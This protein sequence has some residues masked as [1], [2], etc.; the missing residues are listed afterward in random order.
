M[1][2]NK[3]R[4]DRWRTEIDNSIAAIA[5]RRVVRDIRIVHEDLRR[6]L[7]ENDLQRTRIAWIAALTL[8]RSVGHVLAKVDTRR[9]GWLKDAINTKHQAVKQDMFHNLIFH[10]FIE[11]ERNVVIKEYKASIFD[12]VDDTDNGKKSKI[13]V[14]NIQI[15]T[16]VYTPSE[17]IA[18]ALRYWERYLDHVEEMALS[19]RK[20][21]RLHENHQR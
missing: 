1:K 4:Q 12:F 11:R 5:A 21:S 13:V 18:V 17:A 7:G 6:A 3:P 19:S 2:Q 14:T 15:G 16:D 8:L 9:A 20:R 10:E